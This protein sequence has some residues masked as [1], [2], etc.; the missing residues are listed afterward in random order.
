MR[1]RSNLH[2]CP[3]I[4]GDP[5]YMLNDGLSRFGSTSHSIDGN[6]LRARWLLFERR[7]IARTD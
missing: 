7:L 6:D 1:P 4:S 2:S 5:Y 3:E